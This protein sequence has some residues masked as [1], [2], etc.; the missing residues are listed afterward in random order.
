MKLL[1]NED[2]YILF[3]NIAWKINSCFVNKVCYFVMKQ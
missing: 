3:I 1:K 2:S